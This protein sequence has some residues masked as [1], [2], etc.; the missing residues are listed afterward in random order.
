MTAVQ[1]GVNRRLQPV[2]YGVVTAD[3]IDTR[4]FCDNPGRAEDPEISRPQRRVYASIVYRVGMCQVEDTIGF[5]A[6]MPQTFLA[7]AQCQTVIFASTVMSTSGITLLKNRTT[8]FTRSAL[9]VFNSI[10]R[11]FESS[12]HIQYMPA[13]VP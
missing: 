3:S 7:A 11:P 2:K 4:F 10:T 6:G 13:C 12:R 9:S 8:S 5:L 1:N